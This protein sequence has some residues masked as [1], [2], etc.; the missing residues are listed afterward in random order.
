MLGC[1]KIY[2]VSLCEAEIIIFMPLFTKT[3]NSEKN[4]SGFTF[5]RGFNR[6]MQ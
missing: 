4:I 5:Y 2:K 1:S 6:W 3:T